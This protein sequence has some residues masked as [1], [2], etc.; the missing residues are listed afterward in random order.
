MGNVPENRD[1][2]NGF[3]RDIQ[4]EYRHWKKTEGYTEEQ[5]GGDGQGDFARN[6]YL[7]YQGSWPKIGRVREFC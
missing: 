7:G 1:R 4:Y 3:D 5:M 6:L 2:V